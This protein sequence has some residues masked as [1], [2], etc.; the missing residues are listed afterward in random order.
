MFCAAGDDDV[1]AF[2]PPVRM[3]PGCSGFGRTLLAVAWPLLV[4]VIEAVNAWPRDTVDRLIMKL[5]TASDAGDCTVVTAELSCGAVT[6]ALLRA[7]VPVA[8]E[9]SWRVPG[10]P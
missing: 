6:T 10:P 7:S 2:A 9:V 1:V 8:P 3:R 5:V 4:T